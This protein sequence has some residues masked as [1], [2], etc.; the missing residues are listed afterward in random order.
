MQELST[1]HQEIVTKLRNRSEI[2]FKEYFRG[3]AGN[4]GTQSIDGYFI[5]FPVGDRFLCKY[6]VDDIPGSGASGFVGG[7]TEEF[8]VFYDGSDAT[9]AYRRFRD[10][11]SRTGLIHP[12]GYWCKVNWHINRGFKLL[13]FSAFGVDNGMSDNYHW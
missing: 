3:M 2:A 6:D 13:E 7:H 5:Y 10:S 12:K 4:S 8:T 9:I 11:Y 1:L